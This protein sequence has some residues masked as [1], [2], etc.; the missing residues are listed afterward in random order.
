MYFVH[1]EE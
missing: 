1:I